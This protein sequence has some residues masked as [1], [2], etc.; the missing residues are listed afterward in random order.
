MTAAVWCK[1]HVPTKSVI[2]HMHEIVDET[3]LNA[4]QLYVQNFKQADLTL[5]GTVR[6]ATLINQST[7][8][9]T[10][11]PVAQPVGRRV[12]TANSSGATGRPNIKME[13][14]T[15]VGQDPASDENTCATCNV[16]LTPRWWPFPYKVAETQVTPPLVASIEGSGDHEP[17]S[18]G[19]QSPSGSSQHGE[20]HVALAAAALYQDPIDL[21]VISTEVQCH[22]CHWRKVKKEPPPPS[23]LPSPP[24]APVPQ[25]DAAPLPALPLSAL[26]VVVPN[27]EN[28]AANPPAH[29][30][31]PLAPTYASTGPYSWQRPSPTLQ[32]APIHNHMNGINSPQNHSSHVDNNYVSQSSPPVQAYLRQ[33]TPSIAQSPRQNGHMPQISNGYPPSPQRINSSGHL[34]NGTYPSYT[35]ARPSTHHLTNGG[36]PPRAPD[37]SLPRLPSAYGAPPPTSPPLSRETYHPGR[38]MNLSSHPPS[39]MHQLHS[40]YPTMNLT[41]HPPSFGTHGSPLLMQDQRQQGR[42]VYGAQNHDRSSDGQ[43]NGGGASASPSVRNLLS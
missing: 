37:Y 11:L 21:E 43:V 12:S 42:E 15:K 3:G 9:L 30:A 22:Q 18:A 36:P 27:P 14:V 34:P 13:E 4:L 35:S 24:P 28:E 20:N 16:H 7:K 6:K 40:E 10:P 8:A 1:E 29:Y 23:P 25:Q 41:R 26:D 31:W 39:S 2:H 38:E 17:L 19:G 32:G 33:P 5:T